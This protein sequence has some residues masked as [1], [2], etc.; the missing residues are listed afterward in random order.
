MVELRIPVSVGELIDK[1]TI[2]QIKVERISQASQL[3]NVRRELDALNAVWQASS[4]QRATVE[5][6]QTELK[7]VNCRLWDI[8][9]ALRQKESRQQFDADFIALARRVYVENDRRA[10]VKRQIN[11]ITGS[12]YMEEKSYQAY[13]QDEPPLG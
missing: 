11:Q 3:T 6:L 9:D 8:E 5:P 2:L 12:L 7:A 10:A 4:H 1:I 13:V